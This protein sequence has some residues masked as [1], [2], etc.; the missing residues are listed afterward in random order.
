MEF[1][2]PDVTVNSILKKLWKMKHI[3]QTI[4]TEK[5]IHL[6]L[7]LSDVTPNRKMHNMTPL[8]YSRIK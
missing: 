5:H 7:W 4:Q 6:K 1:I 3:G 2:Q 8:F